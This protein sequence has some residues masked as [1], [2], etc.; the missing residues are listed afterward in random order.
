[1]LRLAADS[2][3]RLLEFVLT[4]FR[5]TGYYLHQDAYFVGT[6]R[7][8]VI[9]TLC[10]KMTTVNTKITQKDMFVLQP[11]RMVSN[12]YFLLVCLWF[13]LALKIP[14]FLF[15]DKQLY[16]LKGL[17]SSKFASHVKGLSGFAHTLTS[18]LYENEFHCQTH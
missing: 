10:S 8:F 11:N 18:T 3:I 13:P 4:S 1:M 15:L 6:L 5:T 12:G 9:C 16:S 2:S 7:E 14:Y 17:D